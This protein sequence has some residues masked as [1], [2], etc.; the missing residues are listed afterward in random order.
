MKTRIPHSNLVVAVIL[1]A[2]LFA[3]GRFVF[4]A[5]QRQ[6]RVSEVVREVNVLG[7]QAAARRV[8]TISAAARF[9]LRRQRELGR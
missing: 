2:A 7:A 3:I 6:A 4:A 8:L 9:W 5:N 1:L